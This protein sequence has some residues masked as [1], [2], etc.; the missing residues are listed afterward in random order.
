MRT[1]LVLHEGVQ[2]VY[3]ICMDG[4]PEPLLDCAHGCVFQS[5]YPVESLAR[6][7][8]CTT[9]YPASICTCGYYA[10]G[11]FPR[12]PWWSTLCQK[13]LRAA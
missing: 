5:V 3:H 2:W 12:R 10:I 7:D 9:H 11:W 13:L 1:T 6:Q 4:I 8:W